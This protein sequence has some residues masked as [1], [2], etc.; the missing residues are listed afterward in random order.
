MLNC[1]SS[2]KVRT[3]VASGTLSDTSEEIAAMADI[4]GLTDDWKCLGPPS[5]KLDIVG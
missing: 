1:A 3:R 4:L 2:P 5:L